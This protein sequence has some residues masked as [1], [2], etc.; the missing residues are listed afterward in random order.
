[1]G[2]QNSLG[3][4]DPFSI[5]ILLFNGVHCINSH[6]AVNFRSAGDTAIT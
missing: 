6:W 5:F 1:M 4:Q 3:K 2:K